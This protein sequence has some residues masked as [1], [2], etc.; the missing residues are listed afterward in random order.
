MWFSPTSSTETIVL[1]QLSHPRSQGNPL[2][3]AS[4]ET[5]WVKT[6]KN[7]DFRPVLSR[8]RPISETIERQTYSYNG[9]LTRRCMGF[10]R[11]PISITLN[12]RNAPPY[13]FLV[14]AV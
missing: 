4:N 7:A 11:V 14:L 13:L 12:D 2:A 10:L 6:A 3:T 9:R 5:G 1:D 8:Y